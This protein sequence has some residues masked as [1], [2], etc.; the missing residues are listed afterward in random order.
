MVLLVA[1]CVSSPP[2]P[3]RFEYTRPQMGLPFRI[4]LYAADKS[5]ADAAAEA[6]FARVKQLNDI[7]SDYDTD[8]ELSRLNQTAGSGRAVR[9]GEDLWRVLE[10]SQQTARDTDGAFDITCGPIVSLWR[11]ARREK[12]LPDPGK[13]AEAKRAVGYEKLKLHPSDHAV[14][15][16]VP[17]MRLDLGAIAKSYALDEAMKVLRARGIR[18]ALITGSGDMALS[19]PP[20][21]TAGWRIE[22]APLDAPNAPAPEFVLLR[23][24]GLAT[25][26]DLFQHVEI[27]GVRYSHIVN[28]HTG[29]GLTDH[30]LV[31][32][33]AKDC[34][35]A[36]SI[37]TS[38]SVL[39][40][41]RG[42]NYA[43]SQEACARIVRQ[44]SLRIDLHQSKCFERF[45]RR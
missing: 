6:A 21:G 10:R 36:N 20:P 43:A 40:P 44:P 13:L 8:S 22:L 27:A 23:D 14:E 45:L 42:L 2:P 19:G 41:E 16:L 25:S 1:G 3:A 12:M 4:V 38:A 24:A 30:G 31:V 33:I 32:V 28:P 11:K 37:S 39:G 35:T 17:Y 26:G 29:M 7:L 5:T 18:S 15:L 9:V 34:T